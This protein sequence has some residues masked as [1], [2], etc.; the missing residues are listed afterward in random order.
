M[1]SLTTASKKDQLAYIRPFK[2]S[3]EDYWVGYVHYKV[4]PIGIIF[5]AGG[6]ETE[7]AKEELKTFLNIK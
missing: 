4:T 5:V 7:E 2:H 1:I 6:M 3:K